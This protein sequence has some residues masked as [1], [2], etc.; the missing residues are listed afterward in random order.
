[1]ARRPS[2]FSGQ[3]SGGA[4]P[5]WWHHGRYST[6]RLSA[7]S[8]SKQKML[9]HAEVKA[10][11]WGR[12]LPTIVRSSAWTTEPCSPWWAQRSDERFP[13]PKW[14]T[15]PRNRSD[16]I[17][18]RQR[19]S[20]TH[21]QASIG[22]EFVNRVWRL[23]PIYLLL[24]VLHDSLCAASKRCADAACF[25]SYTPRLGRS[26]S[27]G[28]IKQGARAQQIRP[29]LARRK[30]WSSRMVE[31]EA[32]RGDP[33]ISHPSERGGSGTRWRAGPTCRHHIH[34]FGPQR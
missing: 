22:C 7:N 15:H 18:T 6:S 14:P 20:E 26:L 10:K 17:F 32:Y 24:L 11:L 30:A 34:D 5:M 12:F 27:G 25:F 9:H 3:R 28:K 13:G 16:E 8:T 31:E 23:P 2:S 4:H 21:P 33:G 29:R 19:T 1:M